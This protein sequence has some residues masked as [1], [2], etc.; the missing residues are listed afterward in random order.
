VVIVLVITAVVVIVVVV[1]VI[2]AVVVIVV[3]VLVITAVVVISVVTVALILNES[4]FRKLLTK[5]SGY[6]ILSTLS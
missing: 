2:T 5:A 1:L 4:I 3:I 6:N